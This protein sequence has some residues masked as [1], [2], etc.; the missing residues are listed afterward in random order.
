MQLLDGLNECHIR[1]EQANSRVRMHG[2]GGQFTIKNCFGYIDNSP[3]LQGPWKEVWYKEVPTKIQFFLWTAA[4]ERLS[5]MNRLCKQE[6]HLPSVFLFCYSSG[7]S[8]SHI[9]IHCLITWEIW[10]RIFRDFGL[11]FIALANVAILLEG[12]RTTA[13]NCMGKQ[14]WCLVPVTVC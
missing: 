2:R 9:L 11:C 4:Q 10:C 6:F 8:A 7:E 5:T 1:L 14:I 13:L 3:S 12:R